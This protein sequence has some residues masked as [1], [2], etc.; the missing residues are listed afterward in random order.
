MD[1]G[2]IG[3]RNDSRIGSIIPLYGQ[4]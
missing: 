3:K 1:K 4:K 2:T